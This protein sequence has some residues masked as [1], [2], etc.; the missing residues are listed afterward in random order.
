MKKIRTILV[1]ALA[2]LM[3]MVVFASCS[4]L[5]AGKY[6]AVSYKFGPLSVD[7]KDEETPSFVQLKANKE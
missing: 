7:L 3:M 5:Q 4:L 6:E 1:V 2:T